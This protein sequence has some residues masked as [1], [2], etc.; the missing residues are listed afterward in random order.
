MTFETTYEPDS[1]Q[2][3]IVL[4][5]SSVLKATLGSKREIKLN[6]NFRELENDNYELYLILHRMVKD[7]F[8][9][10]DA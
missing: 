7:L 2:I 5:D 8:R 3:T 1:E 10:Q 4:D 6:D 9:L